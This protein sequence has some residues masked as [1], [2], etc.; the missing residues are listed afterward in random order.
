MSCKLARIRDSREKDLEKE[1]EKNP[2]MAPLIAS[3]YTVRFLALLQVFL[4]ISCKW[5]SV[6]DSREKDREK[7]FEKDRKWHT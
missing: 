5:T 3:F 7:E 6:C 2:K 1:S 4:E